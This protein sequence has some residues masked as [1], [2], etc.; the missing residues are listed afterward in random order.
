MNK[1][2][3]YVTLSSHVEERMRQR[4]YTNHDLELAL[5][6][7][8]PVGDGCVV[9]KKDVEEMKKD[10]QRLERLVGT[11]VIE[12]EGTVVTMYRPSKQRRRRLVRQEGF[13]R[14]RR[15]RVSSPSHGRGG[16]HR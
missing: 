13:R 10:L 11:L 15:R 5:F 6:F 7:G 14:P 12:Q 9:T 3:F 8:T 1:P 16:R 2:A 4:G